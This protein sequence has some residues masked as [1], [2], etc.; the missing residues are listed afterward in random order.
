M[1]PRRQVLLPLALLP[2]AGW[3]VW[4][5]GAEE[6]LHPPGPFHLPLDETTTLW[7]ELAEVRFHGATSDPVFPAAV[8]ALEGTPV[9]L[10]GFMVPLAGGASHSRF[11]LSANPVGCSVCQN[12]RP[13]TMVQVQARGPVPARTDPMT[14][15]GVLRLKPFDGLFYRIDRAETLLV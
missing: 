3:A 7:R 14:V 11:I 15:S 1:T 13:S 9:R 6:P 2:V 12:P 4:A 5:S 8:R 10:R